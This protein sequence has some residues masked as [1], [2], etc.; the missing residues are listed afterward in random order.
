MIIDREG[1][2]GRD[3][4]LN[5]KHIEKVNVH[6]SSMWATNGEMFSGIENT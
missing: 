4:V 2:L 1:K 5:I 6:K 3:D